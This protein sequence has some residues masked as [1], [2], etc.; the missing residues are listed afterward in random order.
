MSGKVIISTQLVMCLQAQWSWPWPH[1]CLWSAAALWDLTPHC[2]LIFHTR[3]SDEKQSL[4]SSE[5]SLQRS[6][7]TELQGDLSPSWESYYSSH[8]ESY[9]YSSK[10][11]QPFQC[12]RRISDRMGNFNRNL[13]SLKVSRHYVS[14]RGEMI[15][16]WEELLSEYS[17]PKCYL[18][19]SQ[20]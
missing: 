3:Y 9:A 6:G 1:F 10:L 13:K 18:I 16:S 7:P 8:I 17:S 19:S 20:F 5:H 14:Q 12:L 15:F 4:Q 11:F 2:P